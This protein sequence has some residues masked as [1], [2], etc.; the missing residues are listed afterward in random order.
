MQELLRELGQLVLGSVPTMILFLILLGA[1]HFIL[2]RPL[3]RVRAERYKRTKGAVERAMAAIA[4]AD[5]KSQEYEAKLRAAR[6]GIQ[7]ARE[8]QLQQWNAERESV[9]ASARL[10][11]QDRAEAARKEIAAQT[12][13]ARRQLQSGVGRLADQIME[14]VLPAVESAR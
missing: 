3:V 4:A 10:L 1:Y 2:Y 11:A 13:A 9:L 14:A 8:V 5:V 12:E 7:H 6:A